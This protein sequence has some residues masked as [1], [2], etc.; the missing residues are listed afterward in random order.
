M[1]DADTSRRTALAGMAC[2][3]ASLPAIVAAKPGSHRMSRTKFTQDGLTGVRDRLQTH[4]A[5]GFT[6]GLVALLDRGGETETFVIGAKALSGAP[7]QRDTIFRI[8]SMTKLVTAA[9][10]MMLVEE[11]KLRVD[12]PVDRLLPEIANRRVLKR[13]DGPLDDT[14]PAKRPITVEDLLTFRLGWGIQFDPTLPINKAS[15]DLSLAG[16]GM[17]NPQQ[18]YGPDEWM[19]RLG[20]LPLMAQPGEQWLYTTGSDVQGVLVA[21]ASGQPFDAFVRE[22]I[23]GPLGMKDTG[24]YVPADKLERLCTAYM[25]NAGKLEVF[26]DP[27]HSRYAKPPQFPEGDSGLCS[28]LDDLLAFSRM[29]L[30]GGRYPGGRILTEASIKAMTANRLTAEQAKGGEEILRPGH[31]W[32][33]GLSVLAW[34]SMDGLQPGAFGWSGGFG[35]SLY[36]DPA[37]GLTT[38][39]LT[40]RVFDGPDPPALHKDFWAASYRALA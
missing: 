9:A 27:A 40:P 30:A 11:G 20:T 36:M 6:P 22:R 7:I 38:I 4:V 8:A 18:P 15:E 29:M 16:F 26:D 1:A 10:V 35:T 28:T 5:S 13:I 2:A 14:V 21:R 12:E 23:T 25:P 19:R 39:L 32:G 3:I 24:F 34:P 31:G 37:K 33:Y 17:P